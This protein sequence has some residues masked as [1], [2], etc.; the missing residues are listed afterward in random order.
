MWGPV[1]ALLQ[2]SLVF[3]A[4]FSWTL[5]H[6]HALTRSLTHSVIRF[7]MRLVSQLWLW[8]ILP[9]EGPHCSEA[10]SR[11]QLTAGSYHQVCRDERPPLECA[12]PFEAGNKG[13]SERSVI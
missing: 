6:N 5:S 2:K 1:E 8:S 3:S 11:G 10:G 12:E 7:L 9:W 13:T 4:Q